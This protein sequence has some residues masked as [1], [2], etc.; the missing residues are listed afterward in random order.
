MHILELLALPESR[1]WADIRRL[2]P[3]ARPVYGGLFPLGSSSY[4]PRTRGT[5][6][7][8]ALR[9]LVRNDPKEW[10]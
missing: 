10:S 4:D 5:Y 8:P 9:R 7:V 2:I 1:E 6:G 3:G